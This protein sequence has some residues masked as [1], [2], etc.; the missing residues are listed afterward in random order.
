[1]IR[2][3]PIFKGWTVDARLKQ[4]RRIKKQSEFFAGME[5]LNFDTDKGDRLLTQY[6]KKLDKN[7]EEFNEIARAIL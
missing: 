4:F 1:M 2:T 3:L 7:S 6:I 5:Y